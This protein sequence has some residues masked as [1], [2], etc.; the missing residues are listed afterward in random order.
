MGYIDEFQNRIIFAAHDGTFYFTNEISEIK[1]GIYKVN[2][3]NK[4]NFDFK[5]NIED[6]DPYRNI[7]I[8]DIMIDE[9]NLY[10][11]I[12]GREKIGNDQ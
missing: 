9:E 1:K 11:V 6:E 2:K 3:F 10:V 7:L 8:R 12:N 4:T 5:F